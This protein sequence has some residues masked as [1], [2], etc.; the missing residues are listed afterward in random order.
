MKKL[1]FGVIFLLAVCP[2][3]A[4][5]WPDVLLRQVVS[6]AATVQPADRG[7]VLRA[8]SQ[9]SNRSLRQISWK[10]FL[11]ENAQILNAN[12]TQSDRRSLM[13]H[14]LNDTNCNLLNGLLAHPTHNARLNYAQE[15]KGMK[16]IY[17]GENHATR[18]IPAEV[19]RL[20]VSLRQANPNAR[21]L[22]AMEFAVRL[23]E[24]EVPLLFATP[25]T[26]TD[27][28]TGKQTAPF[29]FIANEFLDTARVALKQQ[30]DILALEDNLKYTSATPHI[31]VGDTLVNIPADNPQITDLI[32]RYQQVNA[33]YTDLS[34]LKDFLSRTEWGIIQRNRQ[35]ADYIRAVS[36][37]YDII[38][39]Y[40]GRGH[41]EDEFVTP[42]FPNLVG[43]PRYIRFDFWTDEQLSDTT[44]DVYLQH[45]KIQ[46]E[47]SSSAATVPDL[48]VDFMQNL[49]GDTS[50]SITGYVVC[51]GRTP[52]EWSAQEKVALNNL[53]QKYFQTDAP[54]LDQTYIQV[55]LPDAT[56]AIYQEKLSTWLEQ[57]QS[58]RQ[59]LLRL[60]D[61]VQLNRCYALLQEI[62]QALLQIVAD[63]EP[64]GGKIKELEK[65]ATEKHQILKAI[66]QILAQ[67]A[68]PKE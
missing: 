68:A 3:R 65:M 9:V 21:I 50:R 12:Q 66:R 63:K 24:R 41:L 2:T 46:Q 7:T 55:H 43:E 36:P 32:K 25:H 51:R 34:A 6:S 44:I 56:P 13:L 42:S 11:Q 29:A 20:L 31:K 15:T 18:T 1:L 57:L 48:P 60:E 39:S 64:A 67:N 14:D 5:T 37:F 22:L 17:L 54:I 30:I 19:Q 26:L 47:Q 23:D 28:E 10:Q 45:N 61:P 16:Y 52:Q 62:E 38:I 59:G 53:Y 35:W 33:S 49:P 8:L 40:V 4:H 58:F 27:L